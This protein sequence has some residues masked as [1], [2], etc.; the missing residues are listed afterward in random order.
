MQHDIK[1]R[2][3]RYVENIHVTKFDF[4]LGHTNIIFIQ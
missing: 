4:S 3:N 2:E 1:P